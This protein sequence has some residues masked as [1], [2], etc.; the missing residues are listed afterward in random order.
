MSLTNQYDGLVVRF[1]KIGKK[2][3]SKENFLEM[4]DQSEVPATSEFTDFLDEMIKQIQG[5]R[6]LEFYTALSS[7]E[8]IDQA[9]I[10]VIDKKA[11]EMI[12]LYSLRDN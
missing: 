2:E 7:T 3:L 8:S 1:E 10:V 5:D 12:W 4:I 11:R 9:G 6:A